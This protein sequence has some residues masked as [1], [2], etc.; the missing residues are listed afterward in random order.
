MTRP[1]GQYGV[2]A[3]YVPLSM[4]AGFLVTLILGF[5][6]TG[7]TWWVISLIF[8]LLALIYLRTTYVGKFAIWRRTLRGL[9][10]SGREHAVDIGCGRGAVTVMLAT[11]LSDGRVDG[12]DLWRTHDQ[13]GNAEAH[14]RANL[15]ANGVSERVELHTEDMRELPFADESVDLVTASFSIHNLTDKADR[16]VAVEQAYR[17]LRPGGRIVIADIRAVKEYAATL[18]EL[19]A[20]VSVKNAGFDGWWSAPWMATKTLTAVKTAP[21]PAT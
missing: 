12:V 17:I 2:D 21:G 11:I 9:R 5:L 3:P 6:F 8:L 1:R 7:W 13:S 15:A 18:R 20:E 19:G 16:R 14:T 4:L 10:L